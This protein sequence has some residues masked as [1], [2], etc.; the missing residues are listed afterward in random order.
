MLVGRGRVAAPGFAD[1]HAFL[2]RADAAPAPRY[3]IPRGQVDQERSRFKCAGL[4]ASERLEQL[5]RSAA[6]EL[7]RAE[8]EIFA[9]HLAL[10]RD[11]QFAQRIEQRIGSDLENAEQAIEATVEELVRALAVADDEYLRQRIHDIRDL[12]RWLLRGLAESGEAPL[13]GLPERSILVAQELLPSDLLLVDRDN[14]IGIITEQGGETGHAAI[15]ARSLGIPYVIGIAQV[16][17]RIGDRSHV[18]LDGHTGEVWVSPQSSIRVLFARHKSNYEREGAV[19][20]AE[21]RLACVTRDDLGIS[22]H[23]NI[24]RVAEAADAVR[25]HLDG[26]GLFR[27]EYMF[28]DER[29][30]PTLERQRQ[31]YLDVLTALGGRPLVI[32]TLDL[33]GD[34]RPLFLAPHFEANPKLGLRGLRFSLSEAADLFRTQLEAIIQASGH[35]DVRVLFP[36]VLGGHD[37]RRAS[38]VLDEICRIGKYSRPPKIGAMVETPASVFTIPEIL[39]A[40]D[41]VSIG[42][43]DLTQFMLAAD[44]SALDLLADCSPLHPAVLRAVKEVVERATAKNKPVT[45][46]GEAAADPATAR[47]LVGLGVRNLSMAPVSA[48]R[49]RRAL[50]QSRLSEL[51]Q[52]AQA[53]LEMEDP[54]E[55][56]QLVKHFQGDSG[57][58]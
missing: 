52:L 37:L 30:A 56:E 27:T 36:M 18:L 10:L 29:E 47:V 23:A 55:I 11:P 4:R 8:A 6:S 24:G 51:E 1:G 41:F 35:G 50:R 45:V 2:Y 33:G 46:C 19:A 44:R 53:A 21:E 54:T 57:G 38:A 22:L 49:V 39:D 9:A 14:L 48:A 15:L 25:H 5:Q 7:G 3:T 32:R 34:K 26:V 12:G 20:L 13:R 58:A 28:L 17:R 16:T 31:I 42:T 43:N 40:V